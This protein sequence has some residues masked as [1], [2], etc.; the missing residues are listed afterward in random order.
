[1]RRQHTIGIRFGQAGIG[2]LSASRYST[3]HKAETSERGTADPQRLAALTE[4][5]FGT[6]ENCRAP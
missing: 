3:W 4:S 1:M 5:A 2:T 6:T